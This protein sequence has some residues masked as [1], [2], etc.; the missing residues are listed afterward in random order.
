[1]GWSN[2]LAKSPHLILK[3]IPFADILAAKSCVNCY[4]REG[5]TGSTCLPGTVYQRKTDPHKQLPSP[6]VRLL[7]RL[8]RDSTA[9]YPGPVHMPTLSVHSTTAGGPIH[10]TTSQTDTLGSCAT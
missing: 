5:R 6:C 4:A 2:Q 3:E 10:I 7:S 9:F 8:V 1:M